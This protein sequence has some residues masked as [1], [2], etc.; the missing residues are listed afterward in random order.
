MGKRLK[1]DINRW[2]KEKG[3]KERSGKNL[4]ETNPF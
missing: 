3:L 1:L 2:C 4:F